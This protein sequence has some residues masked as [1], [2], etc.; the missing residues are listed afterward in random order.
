[1]NEDLGR[2]WQLATL[3]AAVNLSP[4]RFSH[5]FRQ[6]IGQSPAR[7]LHELRLDSVLMLLHDSSLSIK[8]VMTQVGLNDPSHFTRDFCRRHGVTPS[9]FRARARDTYGRIDPSIGEQ[10]EWPTD[11]STNGQETVRFANESDR[12]WAV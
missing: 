4:S 2:A 11:G 9:E 1:M 3:A 7:Y 10:Q 8:E 6:H 12:R 5:L